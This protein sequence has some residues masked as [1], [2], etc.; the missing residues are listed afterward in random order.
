MSRNFGLQGKGGNWGDVIALLGAAELIEGTAASAL[1]GGNLEGISGK[2]TEDAKTIGYL[3]NAAG[4]HIDA[5]H[6]RTAGGK[7]AA[8]ELTAKLG[9][10]ALNLSALYV[11]IAKGNANIA[12][13]GID[14]KTSADYPEITWKGFAAKS[15]IA[16]DSAD[17]GNGRFLLPGWALEGRAIAQKLGFAV[18]FS[19]AG[20]IT[21]S[22]VSASIGNGELINDQG[23]VKRL[24][25]RGAEIKVDADLEVEDGVATITWQNGLLET[26]TGDYDMPQAGWTTQKIAAETYLAED[27]ASNS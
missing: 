17:G 14:I 4:N 27:D 2:I 26:D 11:G 1:L 24:N 25:F 22:T 19:S 7:L 21:G 8:W 18:V 13:T 6:T 5:T 9:S 20:D 16:F 15:G 12:I 3:D 23:E 10:G